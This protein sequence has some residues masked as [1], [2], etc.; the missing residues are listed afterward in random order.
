MG[1]KDD[2]E[3]RREITVVRRK[4]G[5]YVYW[6]TSGRHR[7]RAVC[8]NVHGRIQIPTR[9]QFSSWPKKGRRLSCLTTTWHHNHKHSQ[10]WQSHTFQKTKTIW[11]GERQKTNSNSVSELPRCHQKAQVS[12]CSIIKH[13]IAQ[14][15]IVKQYCMVVLWISSVAT[16]VSGC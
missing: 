11:Q 14:S 13:L 4:R 12:S 10:Q 1:E 6:V 16:A 2:Q 15:K 3:I 8:W 5:R 7:K 9:L